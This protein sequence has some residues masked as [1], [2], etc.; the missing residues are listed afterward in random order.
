M[1]NKSK[2]IQNLVCSILVLTLSLVFLSSDPLA[3]GEETAPKELQGVDRSEYLENFVRVPGQAV[4]EVVNPDQEHLRRNLIVGGAILGS[5]LLDRAVRGFVRST[6]YSGDTLLTEI[7]YEFGNPDLVVP[8]LFGAGGL[9]YLTGSSYHLD[10]VLLTF[11]SLAVTQSFTELSKQM[12]LRERPRNS[13]D[14]PFNRGEGGHSFFSGHASGAW[15]ALTIIAGRYPDLSRPAYGL[16]AAIS[17]ARIY[18]DAH[19]LTDVVAGSIAGY[20]VARL[21]L[22]L[23]E[24]GREDFSVQPLLGRETVG[25]ATGFRF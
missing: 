12:V 3:A 19:W 20:G 6:L 11:Q 5:F 18:E 22:G 13:P 24:A 8:A 15:A 16:A 25:V 2:V 23:N 1:V 17:A 9:S 7:L 21:T 14:D 4:R 10:S